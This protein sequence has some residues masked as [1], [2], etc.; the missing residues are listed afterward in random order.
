MKT[1]PAAKP[2]DAQSL[3]EVDRIIHEPARLA[4]VAVL[5]ACESADFVYLRNITGMTQGNLSVHLT[6]LEDAG[7][8]AVEK[9]FVG[10]KPNTLC[11]LTPKGTAAFKQYRAQMARLVK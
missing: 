9:R 8:V 1:E 10:K 7:Y 5:A 4:I 2:V 3:L 11:R 6:K